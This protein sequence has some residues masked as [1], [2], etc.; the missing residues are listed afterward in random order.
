MGP[1]IRY[2][3]IMVLVTGGQCQLFAQIP[4]DTVPR[5]PAALLVYTSQ[6]L[7]F[8]AFAVSSVGGTVSVSPFGVRTST[9]GAVLVNF[10]QATNAIFEVEAPPNVVVSF[11][12]GGDAI[13]TGNNGGSITLRITSADTYPASPYINHDPPP[14][15]QQ[16]KVGGTLMIPASTPPGNYTGN[17]YITFSQQ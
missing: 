11:N 2:F 7:S 1:I 13:L 15:R 16:V 4:T 3:F 14:L 8:G 9:G 10:L 5:D 17:F 6:Q 12:N